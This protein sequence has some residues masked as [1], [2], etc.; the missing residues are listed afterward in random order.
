MDVIRSCASRAC[1]SNH[2]S[3]RRQVHRS[4]RVKPCRTTARVGALARG[5]LRPG[6]ASRSTPPAPPRSPRRSGRRRRR[7]RCGRVRRPGRP[8]PGRRTRRQK[9]L[10]RIPPPSTARQTTWSSDRAPGWLPA[11]ARSRSTRSNRAGHIVGSSQELAGI[12]GQ[13]R[14]RRT[15]ASGPGHPSP[16]EVAGVDEIALQRLHEG[17]GLLGHPLDL[18]M[19]CRRWSSRTGRRRTRREVVPLR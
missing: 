4:N 6:S 16:P 12:D 15:A 13:E 19:A 18:N 8:P 9:P 3:E 7:R 11:R 14:R 17:L 10:P 2:R 1:L 5:S